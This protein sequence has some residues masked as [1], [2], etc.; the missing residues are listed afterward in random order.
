MSDE[1][2]FAVSIAFI[3]SKYTTFVYFSQLASFTFLTSCLYTPNQFNFGQFP[4]KNCNSD[5]LFVTF[6]H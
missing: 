2:M 3:H 4:Q 1:D 5:L 6:L